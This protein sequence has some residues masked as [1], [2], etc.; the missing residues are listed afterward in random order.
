M[1]GALGTLPFDINDS[2]EIAGEFEDASGVIHGFTE[3]HG[4]F[5]T[6]DVP[7]AVATSIFGNDERGDLAGQWLDSTGTNHGFVA[8]KRWL[9][10]A[11]MNGGVS[12]TRRGQQSDT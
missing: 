2:K 11:E 1:P 9:I 3:R 4:R 6:V 12:G 10:A 7:G 5:T 8:L